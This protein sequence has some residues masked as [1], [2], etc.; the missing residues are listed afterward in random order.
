MVLKKTYLRAILNEACLSFDPQKQVGLFWHLPSANELSTSQA[1]PRQGTTPLSA[2][3]ARYFTHDEWLISFESLK[4][5]L[6]NLLKPFQ[7][8]L[9]FLNKISVKQNV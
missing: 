1:V 9:K 5:L 2:D 3:V 6:L 7:L 4:I 8:K